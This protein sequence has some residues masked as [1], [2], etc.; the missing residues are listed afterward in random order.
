MSMQ[1]HKG[2]DQANQIKTEELCLSCYYA[3]ATCPPGCKGCEMRV[4]ADL[5]SPGCK[6]LS[7][8][9]GQPCPYYA[10]GGDSGGQ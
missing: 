2:V 4:S 1:E 8:K 9:C 3:A 6:C 7:V 5:T 10:P